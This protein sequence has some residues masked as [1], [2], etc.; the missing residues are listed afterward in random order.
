MTTLSMG[1]GPELCFFVADVSGVLPV[2]AQMSLVP[3]Q[4]GRVRAGQGQEWDGLVAT[5]RLLLFRLSK[6]HSPLEARSH[7]GPLTCP[8][9]GLPRPPRIASVE[10]SADRQSW[11][12]GLSPDSS[13]PACAL[14]C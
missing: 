1:S 12:L 10:A 7:P 9:G 2:T 11:G 4:R 13:C 5:L 3:P 6:L 14:V 8:G